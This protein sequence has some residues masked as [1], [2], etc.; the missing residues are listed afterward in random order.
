MV[1]CQ[2]YRVIIILCGINALTVFH[3]AYT[4]PMLRGASST[5]QHLCKALVKV[6]LKDL[7]ERI[8]MS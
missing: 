5:L 2:I 8:I 4:S 1:V 7:K 6:I 3:R